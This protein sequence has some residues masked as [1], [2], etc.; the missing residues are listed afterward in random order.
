MLYAV[1][2]QTPFAVAYLTEILLQV[3]SIRPQRALRSACLCR[4]VHKLLVLEQ[5]Y[6]S[7]SSTAFCF[8]SPLMFAL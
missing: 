4:T 7:T 6:F 5:C 1:M 8:A 2:S 3:L